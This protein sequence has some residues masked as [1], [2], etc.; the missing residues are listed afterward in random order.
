MLLLGWALGI[1]LIFNVF[2]VILFFKYEKKKELAKCDYL[3]YDLVIIDGKIVTTDNKELSEI[4]FLEP[5]Q[6][7]EIKNA[8]SQNI[9]YY[10]NFNKLDKRSDIL[11]ELIE[12]KKEG[13]KY[14]LSIFH[15]NRFPLYERFNA[16]YTA[17]E[18]NA[19]TIVITDVDGIIVYVNKKF[20]D[21]T[22][23]SREEAI[24]QNP[25][26]LKSGEQSREFYKN[27]WNTITSGRTWKGEFHNK[28]KNGELYWERALITP[29]FSVDNQIISY[30][31]VKEDITE[32]KRKVEEIDQYIVKLES[33]NDTKDKL[34]SIIAHD[35]KNPFSVIRGLIEV[36]N[37]RVQQ[38]GDETLKRQFALM[39]KASEQFYKLLE[40]L[41]L[42]SRSQRKKIQPK[43]EE[44]E[45][46]EFFDIEIANYQATANK[47]GV[48][49][50][51]LTFPSVSIISDKNLLSIII[52]NLVNNAV[53]FSEAGDIVRLN[54]YEENS[55]IYMVVKDEGVG[56][57][58]EQIEQFYKSKLHSTYGTNNEKGTG[59][60]LSMVLSFAKLLKLKIQVESIKNKGTTFILIYDKLDFE[61]KTG[62]TLDVD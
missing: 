14:N 12:N 62:T 28:K 20:A 22:G 26:I 10:T 58:E 2:L 27:L 19:A 45:I 55:K 41:L 16:F 52:R 34:F 29:I 1:S 23:F 50:Q 57:T 46:S 60:G 40:N 43:F 56:M 5:D 33:L 31:A 13:R 53:K 25:R 47:K 18:Q 15:K 37:N 21:L 49:I 36:L 8:I 7:K 30:I 3:R 54:A 9:A 32:L 51:N 48:F 59:I 11:I 42:W 39:K 4:E 38:N 24:G 44:I 35:L 61:D 17:V 6:I